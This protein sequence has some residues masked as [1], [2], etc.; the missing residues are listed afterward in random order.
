[1]FEAFDLLLP[2][3]L[4]IALNYYMVSW[5]AL[6]TMHISKFII[7]W[8][9]A[10][11]LY[12]GVWLHL[13]SPSTWTKSFVY[14]IHNNQQI[15]SKT[16]TTNYLIT[17]CNNNNIHHIIQAFNGL[18]GFWIRVTHHS[19]KLLTHENHGTVTMHGTSLLSE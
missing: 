4:W 3:L 9:D 14:G 13:E 6:D 2:I 18:V 8:L 10:I 17:M 19:S 5:P 1:M 16:N 11:V 7:T 12:H 15:I